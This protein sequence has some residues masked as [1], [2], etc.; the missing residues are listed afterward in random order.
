MA[1][2]EA[3]EILRRHGAP[4]NLMERLDLTQRLIR[5]LGHDEAIVAG[6]GNTSFDLFGAGHRPQNFYM[7][8]SMGMAVPIGLGLALAQPER[9]I[10]VLEGDGS[11]L[12]NLGA[13]STVGMVA[14]PNL[15]IVVWDNGAY[16]MTGNQ[17]TACAETTDL[18]GVAR[19]AGIAASD[20]ARDEPHFTELVASAL[21][22]PGPAFI[23]ARV[24]SQPSRSHPEFDPVILKYR[25]MLGIGARDEGYG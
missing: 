12:M 4:P 2:A 15:T 19:A 6:I 18:V 11:L 16:Q 13:L 17:A 20:W 25:F 24:R 22:Q 21:A 8:G 23:G 10:V 3:M 14:P 1:I 9:E 5:L 7:L